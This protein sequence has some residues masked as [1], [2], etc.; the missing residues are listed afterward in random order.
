MRIL[1]HKC[2]RRSRSGPSG[3]GWVTQTRRRIIGAGA[4]LYEFREQPSAEVRA[5]TDVPPV[6]A[7]FISLHI[8]AIVADRTRCFV[9]SLNLD[10]RAIDLNTENG[11]YIQSPGLCGELDDFFDEMMEPQNAWRVH[12]NPDYTIYWEAGDDRKSFQPARGFFQR[13]SDFIFRLIPM[14]SQL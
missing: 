7:K 3:S 1:R 9:G 6:K 5:F 11:L 12:M 8:K 13:I 2:S 10:P 14:E 4:R